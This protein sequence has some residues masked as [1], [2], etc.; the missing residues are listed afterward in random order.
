VAVAGQGAE[1]GA[2]GSLFGGTLPVRSS[3]RASARNAAAALAAA[4]NGDVDDE[5]DGGDGGD[6]DFRGRGRGG[7]RGRVGRG[8]RGRG[9]RGRG[10]TGSSS[11]LGM[12]DFDFDIDAGFSDSGRVKMMC[13]QRMGGSGELTGRGRAGWGLL[14]LKLTEGA[15]RGVCLPR[16]EGLRVVVGGCQGGCHGRTVRI[17]ISRQGWVLYQ[18]G[19]CDAVGWCCHRTSLYLAVGDALGLL[20]MAG[21]WCCCCCMS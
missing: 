21:G 12:S 8:A 1:L 18:S 9:L 20:V 16:V 5:D 7:G 3:A 4:A 13:P 6:D 15:V 2:T 19:L 14:W 11:S 17:H 10:K